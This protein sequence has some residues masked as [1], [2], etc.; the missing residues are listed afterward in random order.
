MSQGDPSNPQWVVFA[1]PNY[2][3]VAKILDDL[4]RPNE[5]YRYLQKAFE[6]HKDLTIRD[7]NNASRQMTFAAIAKTL[8]DRS[9]GVPQLDVYRDAVHAWKRV[10]DLLNPPQALKTHADDLL[11][12]AQVFADAKDWR[13][14]QSAYWLAKHLSNYF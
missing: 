8:G 6:L 3:A 7:A 9:Q 14:A 11:A 1:V 13:D 5:A 4:K 12:M 10:A 2:E